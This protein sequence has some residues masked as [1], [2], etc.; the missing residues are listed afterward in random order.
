V[1]SCC[2][3]LL[4]FVAE[5]GSLLPFSLGTSVVLT[6]LRKLVRTIFFKQNTKKKYYYYYYYFF[7]FF[8]ILNWR[9]GGINYNEQW[10]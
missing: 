10:G 8:I 2:S 1:E 9:I 5:N 7:F 3:C 4:P 6:T